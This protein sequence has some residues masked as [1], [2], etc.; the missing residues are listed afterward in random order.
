M[1]T[2]DSFD[3]DAATYDRLSAP[4]QEWGARVLDRL[5]LAGDETVLDVG[6]GTGRLTGLLAERLPRGRIVAV[7][8][9]ATMLQVARANLRPRWRGRVTFVRADAAALPFHEA[10]DVIF[11]TATFHWVRDHAALFASLFAALTPGGRLV[12]Q[13]GGGPN[14]SRLLGRAARLAASDRVARWF[15]EWADPWYFAD[16][17]T[18]ARRLESAGFVAVRTRAYPSPVT[19]PTAEAFEDFLACV[20]VRAYVARLPVD[21]RRWFLGALTELASHDDPAF[22]LDY[23]RLDLSAV[24][25]PAGPGGPDVST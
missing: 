19:F 24:K 1:S 13:C 23:W 5:S 4:Q 7:D 6:C 11:S 14:L 8:R 12:A 20:C 10:A 18:T 22:T 3:W 15:G 9:S 16:P 21:E 2:S 17:D 25:P